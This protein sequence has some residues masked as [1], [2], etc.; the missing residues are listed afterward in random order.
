MAEPAPPLAFVLNAPVQVARRADGLALSGAEG[1]V[2]L[3]AAGLSGVPAGWLEAAP[4]GVSV[5]PGSDGE[6]LLVASG[7]RWS[8]PLNALRW[9]RPLPSLLLPLGQPFRGAPWQ[10][11]VG[12]GLVRLLGVPG[13]VPLL[14]RWHRRRTRQQA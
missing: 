4:L 6:W 13:V 3:A 1:Q 11:A 12:R 7:H 8:L 9:H 2:H 10:R 5:A 14:I